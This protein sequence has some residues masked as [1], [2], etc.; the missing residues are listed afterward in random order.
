MRTWVWTSLGNIL[1]HS[2]ANVDVCGIQL[3]I[4]VVLFQDKE[5]R[6]RVKG[7]FASLVQELFSNC[8][9]M[10][11]RFEHL[12]AAGI[13]ENVY[14]GR[15]RKINIGNLRKFFQPRALSPDISASQKGV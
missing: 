3:F 4:F 9:S 11:N 13:T 14:D 15:G 2:T 7:D 6:E 1:D 12:C 8:F 5:L 10:K